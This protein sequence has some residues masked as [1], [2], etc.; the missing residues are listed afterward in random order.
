MGK[1]LLFAVVTIDFCQGGLF[2]LFITLLSV[3]IKPAIPNHVMKYCQLSITLWHGKA[4]SKSFFSYL[5]EL[6][7]LC[8]FKL[9][10]VNHCF[11]DN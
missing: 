10:H 11:K 9:V 3:T 6:F 1:P 4:I 5:S 7:P 8:V 2:I